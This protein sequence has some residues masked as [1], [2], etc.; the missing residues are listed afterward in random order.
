MQSFNDQ[1]SSDFSNIFEYSTQAESLDTPPLPEYPSTV[2]NVTSKE[3]STEI[4]RS[5]VPPVAAVTDDDFFRSP[6]NNTQRSNELL[7]M[8]LGIV[9]GSLIL[10]V[11]VFT[12][13]CRYRQNQ[14]KK[15]TVYSTL[16]DFSAF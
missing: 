12:L 7:Y 16:Q 13:F 8:V 10:L 1:L 4:V 2:N 14:L 11:V 5:S 6:G 9:V 15:S 3:T